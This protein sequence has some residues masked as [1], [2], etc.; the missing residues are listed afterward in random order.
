MTGAALEPAVPDEVPVAM[1]VLARKQLMPVWP[2]LVEL[3]PRGEPETSLVITG[4]TLS[5]WASL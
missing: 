2:P 1:Q 3:L 4:K 5:S